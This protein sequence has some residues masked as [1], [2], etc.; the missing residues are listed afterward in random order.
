MNNKT[1][2]GLGLV[3]GLL[4]GAAGGYFY[5][6][7]KLVDDMAETCE[8]MRLY[9]RKKYGGEDIEPDKNQN[10][11]EPVKDVSEASSFSYQATSIK[12]SDMVDYTKSS[13]PIPFN[14]EVEL[15]KDEDGN[16]VETAYGAPVEDVNTEPYSID[17]D[18]YDRDTEYNKLLLTWYEKNR[19]MA[20]DSNPHIT[21]DPEMFHELFG[22]FE[23]HFGDWEKDT[24]YIRNE[25]EKTDYE[26]DACL[27]NYDAMIKVVRD[28]RGDR[29]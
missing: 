10:E 15:S 24:V 14:T 11:E 17:P 1:T 13:R 6:K 29:D 18:T 21:I 12:E 2:F 8:Q 23:A 5:T 25:V 22:D 20:Y 3:V 4:A 27:V 28:D 7:Y 16:L 19:V 9:Y 26:I